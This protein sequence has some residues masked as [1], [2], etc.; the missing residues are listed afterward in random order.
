MQIPEVK[1]LGRRTGRAELDEH[2]EGVH[3]TE[4]DV[5]LARS[6]RGK[7]EVFAHIRAKLAVLPVSVAIGQP[8][9]HRLDHMLSGVQAQIVVKIFGEDL[10]TLRASAARLR[11]R[12]QSVPGLV[13]LGVEKQ[14][15][16]PQL[17][18]TPDYERAALYGITPASLTEARRGPLQRP[19]RLADRR[20]QPP[21]RCRHATFRRQS[22]DHGPRGP[23][24]STP[25]GFVPLRLLAKIEESDGPTKS[26]ARTVSAASSCRPT[27]TAGA[28]WRP[29]SPTCASCRRDRVAVGLHD[30][31]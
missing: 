28:T 1:S 15:L 20:G 31:T 6:Q 29:S 30:A 8:I 5:D 13:D 24:R 22:L 26:C 9:A 21:L 16:I 4:I 2:A 18:V 11:A 19:H 23:A 25:H 27:A 3:N 7:E 10:D 17:K 14:V 12:L